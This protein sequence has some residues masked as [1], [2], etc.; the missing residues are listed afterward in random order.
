MLTYVW[1][2]ELLKECTKS[3]LYYWAMFRLT[4]IVVDS[5]GLD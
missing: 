2:I 1:G 4:S 3:L 5:F